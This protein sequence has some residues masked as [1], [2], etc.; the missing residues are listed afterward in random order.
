MTAHSAAATHRLMNPR[1]AVVAVVL[2]ALLLALAPRPARADGGWVI[3]SFDA[4]YAVQ[5]DGTIVATE[6]IAADFGATPKHGIIR[7]IP[8]EYTY[9]SKHNRVIHVTVQSVVD[10]S[11][12]V[13]YTTSRNGANLSIKIGDAHKTVTG[14][15][16]YVIAYSVTGGLNPQAGSDVDEFYWN[17][18]GNSWA[19]PIGSASALVL[20][21]RISQY[22]CFEGTTGS[23]AACNSTPLAAD[24]IQ[25]QTTNALNPGEG[26]TVVTGLPKGTVTVP[27][28]E[29]ITVK[30]GWEK[31]R[32]F[33]GLDPLPIALAI[34][35][36]IVAI[37]AVL[38][39][40]WLQGRD[41]WYGDVHY[42]T[43]DNRARRRPL[44]AKDTIVVEY[45][46]P[47][48]GNDKRRLRPAEIGTL[49]DERADTLD[50]T[51]SIID[52]AV[53]GY[54]RITEVP[55]K[56]A[57]GSVDYT[58]EKLKDADAELLDY[59]RM[60]HD[61]LFD[62]GASV[63]MSELRNEFYSDLAAVKTSLYA[64]VVN[65]DRFFPRNPETMRTWNLVGAIV[66]A[67]AG[68]VIIA[69]LGAVG[70][71]II[72]AGIVVAGLLMLGLSQSMAR[73]TAS[74]RET[75]RRCLGFRLYM[76]VAETDRQKFYEEDGIFEKY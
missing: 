2:L 6:D 63:T 34:L 47:E 26:L 71:G 13:P 59:E 30:S 62:E 69:V 31:V 19:V 65:K 7:D 32:D 68:L 45:T 29:L 42:L 11:S 22:R 73:R 39:Y 70:A 58:L 44:F 8:V 55:K 64:Q 23:N 28:L 14:V 46:P 40:W 25:F 57:F 56:W 50:V 33:L 54:L 37:A 12:P 60:L 53:R 41:Q 72:G 18:T 43:G 17:V 15:H 49:L 75:Y 9:D 76:T 24:R 61:R 66:L 51:S 38:R 21:P 5:P 36:G 48:V 4:M 3:R 20:A 52:L 10:G 74:G 35:A 16:K 1:I 67:G 27:P